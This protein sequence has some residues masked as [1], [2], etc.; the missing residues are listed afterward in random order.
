VIS[1]VDQDQIVEFTSSQLADVK[2]TI[3]FQL[4]GLD[5]LTA[6]TIENL[7]AGFKSFDR[8]S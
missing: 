4:N 5:K 6:V 7:T 3:Q 1:L 2:L 8:I